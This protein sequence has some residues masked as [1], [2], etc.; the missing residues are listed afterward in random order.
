MSSI[1]ING[2]KLEL[3]KQPPKKD[4]LNFGMP[5][6]DQVWI[7]TEPPEFMDMYDPFNPT[8]DQFD[9]VEKEIDRIFNG[10]WI[11]IN[12]S[13]TWITG[14]NYFFLKYWKLQEGI[15]PDYRD[16]DR[17][18]FLWWHVCELHTRCLGTVTGKYRRAGASS[19]GSCISVY[20]AITE[21]NIH[22][23]TISKTGDD[24]KAVFTD[25]IIRGFKSLP[26]FFKPQSSG[27]DKS[28]KELIIAKQSERMTKDKRIVGKLEG[29][30]NKI[31]WL[32]TAIN[33]YDSRLLRFLFGDEFGKF[34]RDVPAYKY[35]QIVKRCLLKGTRRVGMAYIPSTVNGLDS[36]GS[37]FKKIWDNSNHLSK[38][39]DGTTITGLFKYMIPCYRGFVGYVGKYGEDI[40]ENPT[41]DQIEWLKND[42]DCPNPN[43]G[44][45]QYHELERKR[46]ED[47]PEALAE[48]IRM[49]PFTEDE[50]FYGSVSS[51]IIN[52]M[53][54]NKQL[55]LLANKIIPRRKCEFYRDVH[56]GLVKIRDTEKG[57][58]ELIWNFPDFN[59]S[60]KY[61]IQYGKKI[62][63]YKHLFS[64][65]CDPFASSQGVA[66][67]EGSKGIAY[68]KRAYNPM[69]SDNSDL[70]IGRL[71][72]RPVIKSD[73][74]QQVFLAGE[75]FG[76]MVG[77]EDKFDDFV[78]YAI[79]NGYEAY[80]LKAPSNLIGS[81]AKIIK[82][83]I[84]TNSVKAIEFHTNCLKQ[85]FN[86]NHHKYLFTELIVD[87]IKFN[88]LDRTI[89]DD[90]MAAGFCLITEISSNAIPIIS[91]QEEARK[92]MIKTYYIKRA[93]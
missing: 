24:A 72:F 25:M 70:F 19:K 67:G 27:S 59:M 81:K 74:H 65:G 61:T 33:S 6:K 48:Y 22:N 17:E 57:P 37:E 1:E 77:Y 12:G 20:I 3:P 29:L 66:Y 85:D 26:D 45:K 31:S 63:S 55:A 14:I 39:F 60:N 64:I 51:S 80:M 18:F 21:K 90:T 42:P 16:V 75:Y 93:Y 10:V 41:K 11:L 38:N 30:N 32:T 54:A 62:P 92:P 79:D 46:L 86:A 58:W 34:P 88:P 56:D 47:D 87:M 9:F 78:P 4:M 2:L 53:I 68:I 71:N 69:D 28:V 89:F 7:R 52:T 84:P 73:F 91:K 40:I 43:I 8:K 13:P 36:G 49:N 35:W 76:C 83:G 5:N 50:Q 15:Y 44:A 23:G 82:Y